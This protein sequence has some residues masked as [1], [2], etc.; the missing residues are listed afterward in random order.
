LLD[1]LAARSLEII[2]QFEP[3][4]LSNTAWSFARISFT[5]EPLLDAVSAC[6]LQ[7]ASELS[8]QDVT[9]VAWSFAQ[10]SKQDDP[11]FAAVAAEV[12]ADLDAFAGEPS[13]RHTDTEDATTKQFGMQGGLH[14]YVDNV[15]GRSV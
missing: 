7:R 6:S 5:H 12:K 13:V 11:L 4:E 9:T 2:T 8:V 3:Q 15:E 14:D 1:A 10:L